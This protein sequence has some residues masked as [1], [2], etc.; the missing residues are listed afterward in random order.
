MRET[1]ETLKDK[2]I[3]IIKESGLTDVAFARK[4][5]I[6]KTSVSLLVNGHKVGNPI[7]EMLVELFGEDFK[8][9]YSKTVCEI[10]GEEFISLN[11]R[12]K[13]CSDKCRKEK[14]KQSHQSWV[15]Q[16]K[17]VRRMIINND[18]KKPRAEISARQEKPEKN[19]AEFM[20]GKSYGDRQ[21]EYLL[22][23]QKTQR[24]EIR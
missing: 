18:F 5:G 22:G 10:C 13:M 12:T 3:G 15:T 21:R 8:Q 4:H 16:R 23:I 19:I 7:I 1:V 17:E 9:Y 6:G 14:V 20:S 11:G 2:V 24:M